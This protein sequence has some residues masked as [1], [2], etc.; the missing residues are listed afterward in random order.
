VLE[1][2]GITREH[3][4][5]PGEQLLKRGG[6]EPEDKNP[7]SWDNHPIGTGRTLKILA[8]KSK[9]NKDNPVTK[10]GTG[11]LAEGLH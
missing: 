5:V 2:I 10:R 8:V 7:K 4:S 1:K 6:N 9:A 3:N 11:V